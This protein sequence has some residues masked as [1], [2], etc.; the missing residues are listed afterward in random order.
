MWFPEHITQGFSSWDRL[1]HWEWNRESYGHDYSCW[2]CGSFFW[3]KYQFRFDGRLSFIPRKPIR[4]LPC[5]FINYV[6]CNF[7]PIKYVLGFCPVW[8]SLCSPTS[9]HCLQVSHSLW[10][11]QDHSVAVRCRRRV[12]GC[13]GRSPAPAAVRPPPASVPCARTAENTPS[14][15]T[16]ETSDLD[17]IKISCENT[18]HFRETGNR[19]GKKYN[20]RKNQGVEK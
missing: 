2:S 19:A 14:Y 10:L 9:I 17:M 7:Q 15:W 20:P 4:V 13:T 8:D 1:C 6:K 3:R 11:P 18:H 5:I 12:R 16:G